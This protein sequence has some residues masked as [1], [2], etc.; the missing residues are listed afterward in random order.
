MVL[1]WLTAAGVV[2]ALFF[3]VVKYSDELG[4]SMPNGSASA[5]GALSRPAWSLAVGWIV[6]VCATGQGG[7]C[8]GETKPNFKHTI[9]RAH[10]LPQTMLQ[11]AR[12]N[13]K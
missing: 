6:L 9:R 5:Y 2:V 3:G 8:V 11:Y 13:C 10:S 1:G 7:K 4:S 12:I